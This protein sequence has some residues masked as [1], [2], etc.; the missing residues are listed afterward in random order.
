MD[1]V[2]TGEV[3]VNKNDK[4]VIKGTSIKSSKMVESKTNLTPQTPLFQHSEWELNLFGSL[5]K[6]EFLLT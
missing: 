6:S 2:I 3:M 4:K 1:D 5:D